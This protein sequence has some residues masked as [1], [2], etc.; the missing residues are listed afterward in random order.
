VR[1]IASIL[2]EA[3][4]QPFRSAPRSPD[5]FHEAVVKAGMD[6]NYARGAHV[7]LDLFSRNAVP[8]QADVFDNIEAITGRQATTWQKFAEEHRADF[9]Y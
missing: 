7:T 1:E 9:A 2:T 3:L 5:A 6:P 4:G 8:G